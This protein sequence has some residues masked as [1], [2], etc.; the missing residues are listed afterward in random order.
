MR[1]I[2][3]LIIKNQSTAKLDIVRRDNIADK[4]ERLAGGFSS[5]ED[6]KAQLKDRLVVGVICNH[7]YLGRYKEVVF[8]PTEEGQ[9]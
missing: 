9:A 3:A 5:V 7:P 1:G 2:K 8:Y 6:A 4:P